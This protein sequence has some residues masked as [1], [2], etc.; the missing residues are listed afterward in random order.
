M[1][2]ERVLKADR[3]KDLGDKYNAQ[4]LS[5]YEEEIPAALEE[6]L[7]IAELQEKGERLFELSQ[8]SYNKWEDLRDLEADRE[9]YANIQHTETNN[10]SETE[11]KARVLMQKW[12]GF[13]SGGEWLKALYHLKT[14]NVV[15][16][17]GA[18]LQY[19]DGD[20]V[21]GRA[22]VQSVK[23]NKALAENTGATGGFLVPQEFQARILALMATESIVRPRAQIIR[24]N[25]RTVGIPVLNQQGT[26]AGG[27][28][29]FGGIVTY[30]KDE[31]SSLTASNPT[32]REVLL[33]AHKLTGLTYASNE[34]LADSAV[35]LEDFLMGEMGFP[36][37]MA[38]R[39]D[40]DYMQG[41]GVGKPQGVINADATITHTR[42]AATDVQYEDLTAMMGKMLPTANTI[43]VANQSVLTTLLNMNGPSGNPSYLWGNAV[44]GIPNTLLGR[45][46]I[47]TDKVPALGSTGD[48][49]LYDFNYYLIG[50]RQAITADMSVDNKF[51]LDQMTWRATLRH[52][53]QV[54]L[55]APV[56]YQDGST[57]VSPFVVLGEFST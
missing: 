52:D 54:W 17:D 33:T 49:G 43:W 31:A 21:E 5:V 42:A 7:G 57:Q 56:T 48:I 28:S 3:Y 46:I 22:R 38:H 51:E 25:R 44:S 23:E 39:C 53:G 50:D 29:W 12:G 36:G 2:Q 41:D 8:E 13:K 11:K 27:A 47:F 34:L 14:N 20:D 55:K 15:I 45:P 26:V 16:G 40:Y 37:A 18:G 19:W 10:P 9:A 30:Y 35:A 4:A 24:M 1:A 6:G 32:W